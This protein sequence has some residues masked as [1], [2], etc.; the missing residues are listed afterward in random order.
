VS[1]CCLTLTQKITAITW[2]EQ[3]NFQIYDDKIRF[4]LTR[5]VGYL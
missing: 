2:R 4:V 3:D 1:D 5:L